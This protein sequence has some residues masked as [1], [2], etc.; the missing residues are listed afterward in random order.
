MIDAA[1]LR[2]MRAIADEGSF[3]AAALSL[4]YSQPAISQMV[5]R[6]ETR[7]GTTL[8]ERVGRSVRLTEAG[9]VLARHAGPV[10]SALD[11]AEEEVAAIAGLRS[12]RVRLMAFPSASATLVPKALAKVKAEHPGVTITFS[13][14]EPRESL[15]ALRAGE[16]DLAV[17]FVYEGTDLGR[18]EEDLD[19]FVTTP[20]LDDEV[21]LAVPH[22][23][24]LA[25]AKK[26]D[27]AAL[28]DETWIAGCPRCRG[29]LLQLA[30][31]AGYVPDI[32][33]ET[34]DYVAVM[35]LIA[36]GL[37]VAVIPDLILKTVHH[38]DV[39]ALPMTPASRRHIVAVTTPDLQRVPAV[40]A[41]LDALVDSARSSRAKPSRASR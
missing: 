18:G 17:A 29:H 9:A 23:H 41:T 27:M 32:A 13:E 12:G 35:G 40:K 16:C 15:A 10:L 6:L 26:A 39:V 34:E 7:T 14:A 20:L 4:G 30:S 24:E 28:Q 3:T 19:A 5:R 36:E 25:S 21:L 31:T 38:E 37:G 1:G 2:V 22:D 11:A 8:V 33:Y